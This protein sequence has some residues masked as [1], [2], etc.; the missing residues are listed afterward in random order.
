MTN[1]EFFCYTKA[2]MF[3]FFE[4]QEKKVVVI[5]PAILLYVI[6][7]A[8]T[9]YFL[10]LIQNILMLILLSFILMVALNPMVAYFHKRLKLSRNYSII[11]TYLLVS[12]IIVLLFAF[13]VPP[14]INEMY[15]LVKTLNIPFLQTEV[16]NLKLSVTEIGNL[17][18]TLGGSVNTLLSIIT[19]TFSGLFTFITIMV[20][21][22]YMLV[23]RPR[24][25]LKIAWFSKKKKYFTICQEFLNELEK[26]LGGWVSAEII[27]MCVIALI[28]YLGLLLLGVPFALPL[29]IIAGLLEILPNL[30][31][32]IASI[33][34][35]VITLFNYN[36]LMA[37]I[38]A[39]FYILV[40]QVENSFIVPKV[41]KSN[42]DVN[43]LISIISI[44]I[45]FT[46]FKVMGAF[47]AIPVYII[48]RT[49]YSFW[50][51]HTHK[52]SLN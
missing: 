7:A 36:P 50:W 11:A 31:P 28:T 38:V 10:F 34:A 14:L 12:F 25:H 45:G 48:I 13:V 21:T 40:Q 2:T 51:Q 18:N 33:P 39:I 17:A 35:I 3:N 37:A 29:A 5:H 15:Q 46:L 43:P 20:M 9:A 30:G 27:L 49:I 4:G 1:G 41:M 19:S 26:A 23:D 8:L 6:I 47:L 42:A 32:T 16:T 22:F 24:L 52:G 44:L